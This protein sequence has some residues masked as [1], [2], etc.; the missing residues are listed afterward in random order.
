MGVSYSDNQGSTW[1]ARTCANSPGGSGLD[2][3]HMWID[4]SPTSPYEG[5]LY[6][7]WTAF[8]GSNNNDIEI[9]RSTDGGD[10]WSGVINI[11]QACGAGNPFTGSE[12]SDR[13]EW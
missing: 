2:K 10:T 5:N 12:R 1:T 9:S 4:N 7:T 11:S 3:N 13:S 8:G 6:N